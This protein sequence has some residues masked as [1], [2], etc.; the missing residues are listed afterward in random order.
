MSM[1]GHIFAIVGPSGAGKDT[2]M[3]A[4]AAR[5]PSVVLV[6]RVI[7]R[8]N[9]AGGE[10][11]ESV[12][13]AEFARRRAAGDFALSWQAH[14]LS[15]AIPA[16]IRTDLASGHAV[17]FNGSRAM[18][19]D[20]IRVFP[21]LTIVHIT[22]A[23]EILAARLAARGRETAAEIALRLDRAGLALPAGLTAVELDNSGP[24]D[25]A[26]DALTRLVQAASA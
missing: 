21:G 11:F 14:G 2:L 7:T 19:M 20:S 4:V 15:Y 17:L 24:L 13:E 18:L 23:R 10:N 22:A 12:S 6:R 5:V 3:R 25:V 16:R 26:T 8:P 1:P 9:A